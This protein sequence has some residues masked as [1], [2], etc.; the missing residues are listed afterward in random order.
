MKRG[1]IVL[2]LFL[3]IT[4]FFVCFY[5]VSTFGQML[6]FEQFYQNQ[7]ATQLKQSVDT[8]L[9]DY[10]AGKWD[11]QTITEKIAQVGM[12]SGTQIA[13]VDK[14]SWIKHINTLGIEVRME[15][16]EM[17]KVAFDDYSQL[18]SLAESKINTGMEISIDGFYY[19]EKTR[20]FIPYEIREKTSNQI[21]VSWKNNDSSPLD[22]SQKIT[23]TVTN[24]LLPDN[25]NML[26]LFMQEGMMYEAVYDWFK[27]SKDHTEELK[28][29]KSVE[30]EWIDSLSGIKNLIHI[31]PV[32]HNGKT[33]EFI[34]AFTSLQP[35]GDA[36]VAMKLYFA[37][38]FLGAILLIVV[39]S[40]LFSKMISKPLIKL[41]EV[42][43]RM[44]KLDFS[45]RSNIH[46]RD[47]LGSLSNSLNTLSSNLDQSLQQ[48]QKTNEKLQ[49]E[50]DHKSQIENMRKEFISSAS[51]ELKTPL[52]IIRAY[53]EGLKDGV[54]ESKIDRYTQV[55]L[56]EVEKMNDLVQGMLEL[57]KL[58]SKTNEHK[59]ESFNLLALIEEVIEALTFHL[60]EKELLIN[61]DISSDL[62][63]D[64]DRSKIEQ[65]LVNLLCN[66]IRHANRQ[67]AI[68]VKAEP[69]YENVL[70]SVENQG[71]HIPEHLLARVWEEFYRVE[72]SRDRKSGGT[73]LGLSIVKKILES[74]KSAYGVANSEQGVLFSFTLALARNNTADDSP[75]LE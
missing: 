66:A 4:L 67:S 49:E 19:D 74:H 35:V 27:H 52:G 56:T 13:I 70:I 26:Y 18:K 46:S 31:Q 57:S 62:R 59:T 3:L 11:E 10:R 36:V 73:G 2:K 32:E 33:D 17:V 75:T 23:G 22:N 54:N 12:E 7:K 34:F 63:V 5:S 45:A 61:L 40:Y 37:Y 20:I 60:S 30:Y 44:A 25:Q 24:L 58:E 68:T 6:F 28:Q 69:L 42:A 41:N 15:N 51:H 1:S 48:L 29:G 16:G 8:F 43:L 65:V 39:I 64:A 9:A 55:I 14:D 50:I 21:I 71:E 38:V 72:Q 47:E 53:A